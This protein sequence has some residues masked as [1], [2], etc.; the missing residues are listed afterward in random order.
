MTAPD[1]QEK[2]PHLIRA[3]T[4]L[5][6]LLALFQIVSVIRVLNLPD[7]LAGQV[8]LLTPL[9]VIAGLVWAGIFTATVLALVRKHV[10]ALRY[11][12]WALLGFVLYSIARL[13]FF[14]RADYDRGRLPFLLVI[15][16]AT[17]CIP[18]IFL[19]RTA[20]IRRHTRENF[21][22]GNRPQD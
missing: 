4:L 7:D 11:A 8:S 20:W 18:V 21:D 5:M 14:S 22:N 15:A 3:L 16:V 12:G 1:T 17:L 6:A 19:I 2:H 13:L 10:H 9:D